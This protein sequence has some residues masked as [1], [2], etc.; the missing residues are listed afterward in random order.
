M[1][2]LIHGLRA[3]FLTLVPGVALAAAVLLSGCV[4]TPVESPAEKALRAQRRA[5]VSVPLEDRVARIEQRLFSD[6]YEESLGLITNFNVV[7]GGRA[8]KGVLHVEQ[9]AHLLVGLA[10]KYAVTGDPLAQERAKRLLGG[11]ET[12]DRLNGL[13]GF[14]PLEVRVTDGAIKVVND[15]FVSSSYTQLLYAHLLAWRLFSDP[16]VKEEIRAQSRRM[17]DHILSHGL[18]VVGA[19]GRPLPYSDASIKT[20]IIGT[21]RELETLSFVRAACFFFAD[22]PERMEALRELRKKVEDDYGYAHMPYVLH[23]SLPMIE[24]PT[25]SSSWLSLM[26]LAALVETTGSM[27]Y[28]SLLHELADDYRSHQN[29]FFIALDLLYGPG[30]SP[31]RAATQQ[32]IARRRLESYPLTNDS[33]ELNNRGRPPYLTRIPPRLVKSTLIFEARKPIPFYDLAGDRYLWKRNLLR[34]HGNPGSDG[35]KVYSGVDCYE[36]YWMLAYAKSLRRSGE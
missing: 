29:P 3:G 10:C 30:E 18:V 22:D 5:E 26:K 28:R 4:S 20:R 31:E 34:L 27:K 9:S 2:R 17:L 33:S 19:D 16:Q 24:L 13:D 35:R 1:R 12:L 6:F 23:V 25:A 15:Q 14:L 36:A 11:L 8:E 32:Q 7:R 21:S